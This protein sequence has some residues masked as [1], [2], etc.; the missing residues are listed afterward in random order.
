MIYLVFLLLICVEVNQ[1]VQN[2]PGNSTESL[3]DEPIKPLSEGS[4]QAEPL[5]ELIQK[6]PKTRNVSLSLTSI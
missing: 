1:S 6:E 2:K 5:E 4:L 3:L